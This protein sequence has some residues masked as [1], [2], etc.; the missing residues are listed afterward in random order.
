MLYEGILLNMS[1]E[2]TEMW[3][4][5]F[6]ENQ[7]K[8]QADASPSA[9]TT[10][11]PFGGL[12]YIY[13]STLSGNCQYVFLSHVFLYTFPRRFLKFLMQIFDS[14]PVT[15][16]KSVKK[17]LRISQSHARFVSDFTFF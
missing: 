7:I 2:I 1:G 8:K 16:E 6:D 4:Y 14:P 11:K 5:F 9:Q 12:E 17:F 15:G 13:V 3:S 10:S